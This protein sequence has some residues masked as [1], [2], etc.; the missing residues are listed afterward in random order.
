[1]K[2][3]VSIWLD[4]IQ[5]KSIFIKYYHEFFDNSILN[6]TKNFSQTFII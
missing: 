1:M 5:L 6:K 4:S 3:Q 2:N